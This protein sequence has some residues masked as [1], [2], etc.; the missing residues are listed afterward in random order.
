MGR[1]RRR[2]T[3]G[4]NGITQILETPPSTD[5]PSRNGLS[6]GEIAPP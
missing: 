2:A 5:F 3:I 4:R 6:S 1:L